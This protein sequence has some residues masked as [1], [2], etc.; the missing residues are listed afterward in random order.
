L[1][2]ECLAERTIAIAQ[3]KKYNDSSAGYDPLLEKRLEFL[4]PVI[5]KN[6][7]R[8]IT[9]M[10]AANPIAAANKV[11][12]MAKELGISIKVAA[13]TGDDV[14]NQIDLSKTTL[15]DNKPLSNYKSII[16]ANAY[17]GVEAI[18]PALETEADIIITGRV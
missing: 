15:E 18:L 1:I 11:V 13:V 6:K 4:L 14:L 8:V 10:G 3:K 2:L 17:L 9:N 5:S 16:S 7:V 12:E